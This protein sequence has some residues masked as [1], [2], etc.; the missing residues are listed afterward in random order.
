MSLH[1]MHN[2]ER[3]LV[4]K[5]CHRVLDDIEPYAPLGEFFHPLN[6]KKAC[7]NEGKT[8]KLATHDGAPENRKE[9]M[10]FVKKATRRAEK[11]SKKTTNRTRHA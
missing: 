6:T 11:R 4:C 1:N 10:E 9:M 8:F 2:V 3:K 7:K 5:R